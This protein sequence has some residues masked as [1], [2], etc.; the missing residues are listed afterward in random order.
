MTFGNSYTKATLMIIAIFAFF[1]IASRFSDD[2]ACGYHSYIFQSEINGLVELKY[3][4]K[5]NHNENRLII[6]DSN[7][8]KFIWR[9]DMFPSVLK[10]VQTGDRIHKNRNSLTLTL[11]DTLVMSIASKHCEVVEHLQ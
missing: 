6:V 9:I 3:L 11:N 5:W 2:Y 4:D 7:D 8:N 10:N 1:Y